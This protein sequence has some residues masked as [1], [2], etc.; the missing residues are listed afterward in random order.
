[1]HQNV[2][3]MVIDACKHFIGSFYGNINSI[4]TGVSMDLCN[5]WSHNMKIAYCTLQ[6]RN[7]QRIKHE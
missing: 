6:C 7:K 3:G 5:H 2:V 4:A 1:M